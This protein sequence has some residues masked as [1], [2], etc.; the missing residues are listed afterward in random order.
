[1]EKNLEFLDQERVDAATAINKL[2]KNK[3]QTKQIEN[4]I[5][6]YTISKCS[7]NLYS[8]YN[9]QI[10][11]IYTEKLKT[12]LDNLDKNEIINNTY[13]LDCIKNG[14]IDLN[15]LAF[16][17]PYEICPY[18]W[19]KIKERHDKK[20]KIDKL[21]SYTDEFE[22]FNCGENKTTFFQ[23]QTRSGDEPMTTF[24]E[25]AHCKN[26]WKKC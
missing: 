20:N 3:Y 19:K 5:L 9:D 2:I 16:S 24:I 23:L 11:L 7:S 4:S 21:K 15:N 22:C 8:H 18:K 17:T 6:R 12:L 1:M 13:L 26:K 14:N 10:I 25:C